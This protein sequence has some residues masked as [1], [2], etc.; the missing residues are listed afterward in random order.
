MMATIKGS[1]T[2]GNASVPPTWFSSS[3]PPVTIAD[4]NGHPIIL[5]IGQDAIL[6]M[7]RRGPDMTW[8]VTD[9]N[10]L[11][12]LTTHETVTFCAAHQTSDLTTF[13]VIA[14]GSSTSQSTG[15]LIVLKPFK[16]QD[17][18][19][20]TP[21]VV[22][23]MII[24][25][26]Q[27]GPNG[28]KNAYAS[29]F[30]AYKFYNEMKTSEDVARVEVD[31][32]LAGWTCREDLSLPTTA[33]RILDICPGSVMEENGIFVL[34]QVGTAMSKLLFTAY[35]SPFNSSITC[36]PAS[37]CIASL[38]TS[39][40]DSE[41]FIAADGIYRISAEELADSGSRG[42][43]LL[44]TVPAPNIRTFSVLENPNRP[45]STRMVW[46]IT[47]Q[48]SLLC[49]DVPREEG[50]PGTTQPINV[51][52]MDGSEMLGSFWSLN[53][54]KPCFLVIT[55]AGYARLLEPTEGGNLYTSALLHLPPLPLL[56][57]SYLETYDCQIAV[58]KL[59]AP[60]TTL[61]GSIIRLQASSQTTAV[62]QGEPCILV[63]SGSYFGVDD[64]GLLRVSL[65][66]TSLR[67]RVDK[68]MDETGLDL[69][70]EPVIPITLP[71]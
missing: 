54:E 31:D 5:S 71:R 46:A 12:G 2:A 7:F 18:L 56:S 69:L 39:G 67:L 28:D 19:T 51:T 62:V 45:Q 68:V 33:S 16:P 22:R 40:G 49:F 66:R 34:H 29:I 26:T 13:I 30:I 61:P 65:P 25:S 63:M 64:D 4:H 11:L 27:D 60:Q 10:S 23:Q 20:F 53:K 50:V 32:D 41:I 47:V 35:S 36:P 59:E 6:R 43:Q 3:T 55:T 15:R 21:D 42:T 38:P 1:Y 14:V 44:D 70:S 24:P 37:T 52:G 9:M 8:A 17:V 48:G 58:Q 57:G